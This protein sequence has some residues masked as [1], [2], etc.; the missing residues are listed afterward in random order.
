VKQ[1]NR[2]TSASSTRTNPLIRFRSCDH[3]R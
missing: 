3:D 1:N 2:D